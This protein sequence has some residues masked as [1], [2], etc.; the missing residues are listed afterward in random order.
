[1]ILGN[2]TAGFVAFRVGMFALATAVSQEKLRSKMTGFCVPEL[3]NLTV[4]FG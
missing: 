2:W 1:M 3:E 4:F